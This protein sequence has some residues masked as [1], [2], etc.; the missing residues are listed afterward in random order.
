MSE[1]Q[2][3]DEQLRNEKPVAWTIK[4]VTIGTVKGIIGAQMSKD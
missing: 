1:M 3:A 4:I 2:D